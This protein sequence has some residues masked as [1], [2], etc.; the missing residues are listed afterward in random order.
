MKPFSSNR[1][2]YEY[3]VFLADE[4][5]KKKLDEL[6]EAVT[7]ASRQASGLSTEFLG[8][9]RVVLRRVLK[10]EGGLLTVQDRA[11][12]SDVIAQLDDAFGKR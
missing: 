8:E 5:K 7:H 11:N 1:E 12:V 3:L 10:E 6:S 2:L 4:L 9:S